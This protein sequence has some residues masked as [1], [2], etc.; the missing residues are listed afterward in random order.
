MARRRRQ[1]LSLSETEPSG[2]QVRPH[3]DALVRDEACLAIRRAVQEL[4]ERQQV[5]LVLHRFQG[6]NLSQISETTGW[7]VS[8]VESLL[9][10]AYAE[11]RG[12]LKTWAEN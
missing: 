5:A 9:V 8:A 4:P 7:S 12:R 10:R 11:L 1:P 3:Q 6:L 2:A